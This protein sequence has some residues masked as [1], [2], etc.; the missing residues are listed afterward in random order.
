MQDFSLVAH[1]G[2]VDWL[3]TG[4]DL[5]RRDKTSFLGVRPCHSEQHINLLWIVRRISNGSV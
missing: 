4:F 5:V 2:T 1:L 3:T